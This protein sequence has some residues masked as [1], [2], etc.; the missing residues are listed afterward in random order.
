VGTF[1]FFFLNPVRW[2]EDQTATDPSVNPS[3]K[4]RRISGNP[5]IKAELASQETEAGNR[6]A[7]GKG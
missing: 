6:K 7:V 1:G 2:P 4:L 5:I 3:I